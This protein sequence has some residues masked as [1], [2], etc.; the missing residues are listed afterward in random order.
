MQPDRIGTETNSACCL[1]GKQGTIVYRN[2]VDRLFGAPGE[3]T[4]KN[5]QM[6]IAVLSG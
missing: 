6:P 2:L 1:C 5:A 4:F 3:W